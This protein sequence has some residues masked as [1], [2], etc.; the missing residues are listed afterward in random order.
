MGTETAPPCAK[1]I[2]WSASQ[3]PDIQQPAGEIKTRRSISPPPATDAP[4][5]DLAGAGGGGYGSQDPPSEHDGGEGE[6]GDSDD[7]ISALPDAV[8]Q[9]IISLLPTK[10]AGRTPTLA[11]RW[12]HLW[13]STPLNL[14]SLDLPAGL[15]ALAAAVFNIIS[16]HQ[17]PGRYFRLDTRLL[18]FHE[19]VDAWFQLPA[20]QNLQELHLSDYRID[21]QTQRQ[22]PASAFRFSPHLRVATLRD[23]RI[24]D[25]MAQGILFPHMEKLSLENVDIS[26]ASLHSMIAG[27]PILECLLLSLSSSC[28]V[29]INSASLRS[30]GVS[31]SLPY[32]VPLLWIVEIVIQQAPCLEKLLWIDLPR[33]LRVSVMAGAAPNLKILGAM[34]DNDSSSR[35]EFGSMVIEVQ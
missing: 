15:C 12:R 5:L 20:L 3:A 31:T 16:A 18:H 25:D 32:A 6:D 11:S 21:I 1:K 23:C 9:E 30:L 10:D 22:L 27:C 26:E 17:G 28:T 2:R 33:R 4:D 35:F 24:S 34:N 8:L 29:R 13:R 7:R 19:I 14:D